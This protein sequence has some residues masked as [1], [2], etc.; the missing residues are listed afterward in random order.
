MR[1]LFLIQTH[2]DPDQLARL[3]HTLRAGCPDS[4]VLVSHHHRAKPLPD[5]LFAGMSDI[6]VIAGSGGRGDF[7]IL[8][9]YI[10][11]LRWV[12][13]H[14]IDYDWLTNLSG[15]DYPASS[16]VEFSRELSQSAQDGFLHHFDVLRQDVREMSP[17]R[18][19]ARH[20]YDRYYYK[21]T[22]LKSDL[23]VAERAVIRLPRLA[24]RIF[25]RQNQDQHRLWPDDRMAR[26]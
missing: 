14:K 21:Y 23:N 1:H 8:D 16:L 20:G 12:R 26:Q 13:A 10:A 24:H 3:V 15:Q 9:G 5:S 19:P 25:D 17:M 2:K 4:V 7:S 18:W 22:K 11:A 6:H